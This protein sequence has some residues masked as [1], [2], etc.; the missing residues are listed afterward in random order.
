MWHTGRLFGLPN[1]PDV[2]R[3]VPFRDLKEGTQG[4]G[5]GRYD[6][7]RIYR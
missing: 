6:N 7:F 3:D 5:A 4:Q 2:S 1:E